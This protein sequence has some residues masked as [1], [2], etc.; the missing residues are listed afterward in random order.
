MTVAPRQRWD[1]GAYGRHARFVSDLGQPVLDLLDLQ[2]GER[3]LDLGCGDG[4]LTLRLLDRGAEVVGVDSSGE[5]VHQV[6]AL[7][8]DARVGDGQ[9]LEEALA[10]EAPFDAVFSNAALHWMGD[11]RAVVRGVHNLLRPG[12]RFVGEFGGKGNVAAIVTALEEGL[13]RRGIEASSP[14]FF[15]DAP[16]FTTLLEEASFQVEEL[17]LFPRPTPLPGDVGG[18]L[19]TFAQPFT[20]LLPSAERE[21]FLS[22]LVEALAPTLRDQEGRWLADYVRLRFAATAR[23]SQGR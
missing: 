16:S 20:H 2:P 6:R 19:R 3:V 23:S 12:G 8:I 17:V 13:A 18:W 7:G 14:W 15:P 21:A 1:P 4:A 11:P 5:M 22:E 9:R 10:S